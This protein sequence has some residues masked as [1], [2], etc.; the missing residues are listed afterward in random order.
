MMG[1]ISWLMVVICMFRFVQAGTNNEDRQM[2]SLLDRKEYLQLK[3]GLSLLG[4][5]LSRERRIYFRA[6][7]ENAF[8]QNLQS[9]KDIESLLTEYATIL[10]LR[11]K[12]ALLRLQSNNY[13]RTFAYAKAAQVD[14][15]IINH[16]SN[17]YD[18]ATIKEI[19]NDLLIHGALANT[20]PQELI[21][22][23]NTLLPWTRDKIGLIEISIKCRDSLFSAIFDTR[24][25]ISSINRTYAAKLGLKMLDVSY[26]EGSG[27]T[28]IRFKTGMGI[29]D[30]LY[31]GNIL[32]RHVVFQVMPDEIL[33]IPSIGFSMNIILGFPVIEQLQEVHFF[34][35]GP[36]L[37]P[38]KPSP[39]GLTNFAIDGLDI[40]LFLRTEQNDSLG[41]YFDSGATST[42]FFSI[43]F[44]KYQE[45]ITSA[46]K[47]D[48]VQ[49]GGA[50]GVVNTKVY[51]MD[52]IN[53]YVGK[54]KTTLAKVAVLTD[55][56]GNMHELFYGNIGQDFI[57]Q[58]N[59][60]VINFKDMYIDIR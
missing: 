12:A 35:E 60:L 50:G 26:E 42:E 30:S 47:P 23:G 44:K 52:S 3:T 10:H 38:L 33:N 39:A 43:F 55:P 31:L 25:N 58:A 6:F 51:I 56:I 1:A 27:I 49:N 14:R 20:L 34:R 37:I 7:V 22:T 36:M 54:K 18:S 59:E 53:L 8:N 21:K 15:E 28:G 17:A 19:K 4:S 2:Q 32:I 24:A 16:F 9:E 48:S 13:L 46:F 11:E 40:V 57:S 45:H 5:H 41:F 29:A